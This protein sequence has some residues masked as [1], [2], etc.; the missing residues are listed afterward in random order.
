MVYLGE[1][2]AAKLFWGRMA[3]ATSGILPGGFLIFAFLFPGEQ[4]RIRVTE[5]VLLAFLT[6]LFI[7]LSFTR[8]IVFSLGFGPKMFVYG[9]LYPVFSVYMTG[10]I[11]L[12]FVFLVRTFK[13]AFGI[14][15]LQVKYCLLGM[16]FTSGL[17]LIN[18]LFLPMAGVSRFNWLGPS[19]TVIM[20]G[21]TSYSIVR[22]RLMDINLV[23]K[24]GTTYFLLMSLL[25]VPS[26]FSSFWAR[27][28]F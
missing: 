3:F 15:R 28:C 22:H 5:L 9:P 13:S 14:E 26:F 12:G 20:V 27:R 6:I 8:T 21:F 4:R 24:K 16:F 2:S 18:N 1:N 7:V 17:G 11:V 10:F 23:F 25:F 19:S